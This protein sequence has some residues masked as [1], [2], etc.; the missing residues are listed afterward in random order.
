M[1]DVLYS[2]AQDL[3]LCRITGFFICMVSDIPVSYDVIYD[4]IIR[5]KFSYRCIA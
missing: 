4:T 5:Y 1:A 2:A 3:I